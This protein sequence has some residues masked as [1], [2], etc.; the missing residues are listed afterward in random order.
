[1]RISEQKAVVIYVPLCCHRSYY[2]IA[3][4]VGKA[5]D[6]VTS[7]SVKAKES[8]DVVLGVGYREVQGEV[9]E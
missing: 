8:A 1:L 7:I 4:Y 2:Y 9:D 3:R 5:E 6:G